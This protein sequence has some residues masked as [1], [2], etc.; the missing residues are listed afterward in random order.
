MPNDPAAT[1]V[2]PRL[3]RRTRRVL[4]SSASAIFRLPPYL[5][6]TQTYPAGARIAT[7]QRE[8]DDEFH[9]LRYNHVFIRISHFLLRRY[10]L[11]YHK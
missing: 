3:A 6:C 2:V 5:N 1:R 9:A 7:L 4:V 11:E 10:K 8:T